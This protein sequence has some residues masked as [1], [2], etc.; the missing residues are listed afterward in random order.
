MISETKIKENFSLDQLTVLKD[1]FVLV[2]VESFY[3]ELNLGKQNWFI[4][5]SYNP[6]KSV[7]ANQCSSKLC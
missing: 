6:N 1:R 5:C 3:V 4:S 2:A 7:L